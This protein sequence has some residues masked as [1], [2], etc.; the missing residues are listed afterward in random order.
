MLNR[1]IIYVTN[2]FLLY[3]FYSDQIFIAAEV[4]EVRLSTVIGP[5]AR[6]LM[7]VYFTKSR[8]QLKA[9]V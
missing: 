8:D 7:K 6:E 3:A 9:R 4:T 2:K 1:A 5:S